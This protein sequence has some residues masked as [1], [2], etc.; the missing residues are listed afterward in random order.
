MSSMES[1]LALNT[2]TEKPEHYTY[3]KNFRVEQCTLFKEH[4]CPNHKPFTC[5]H[6][7]FWNQRRRR[8][9]RRR[10]GLFNYSPDVYCTKYDE[11][12][13]I[14]PDGE[15]CP[16][17]HKTA[18]DTEKHYHLRH[19]KTCMC[20]YDTDAKGFCKKNGLHCAYAHGAQDLRAPVLD[21]R[22]IQAQEMQ[23]EGGAANGT[24]PNN[25]D[26]ERNL[27]ED[28][29]WQDTNYVLANYKTEPCKKPPRLCR[30][31]YT[32]PQYHN[33]RD[34]RRSPQKF[35]Y[36]TTPCP[37]VKHLDEWGEPSNCESGDSCQYCHTRTEQQ[38]HPEIYKSSKCN[39]MQQTGYCPRGVFCAFAH[40]D[41]EIT[42]QR[43]LNLLSEGCT[44]LAS[45]LPNSIPQTNTNNS[46]NS[47]S[48]Q[49]DSRCSSTNGNGNSNHNSNLSNGILPSV[50]VSETSSVFG[51]R[52]GSYL[53]NS[54]GKSLLQNV[55]PQSSYPKA[56]GSG[57]EEKESI[58]RK[59]MLAIGSL[60]STPPLVQPAVS[61]MSSVFYPH[62]ETVE[63]VLGNALDDQGDSLSMDNETNKNET[64]NS[65]S[66][67]LAESGLLSGS[68]PVAIP[69]RN[70]SRNPL[71]S[72]TSPSN[73]PR[74][75]TPPTFLSSQMSQSRDHSI[76]QSGALSFVRQPNSLGST[77]FSNFSSSSYFDF[78]STSSSS[79]RPSHSPSLPNSANPSNNSG[80]NY[81]QMWD[82]LQS[83]ITKLAIWKELIT[84]ELS[85]SRSAQKRLAEFLN[86][87]NYSGGSGGH[88]S[89][90]FG[91][92]IDSLS[93]S[94]LGLRQ[95]SRSDSDAVDKVN[96]SSSLHGIW[97]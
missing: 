10:D 96:L 80:I 62:S 81:K 18:G 2:Q 21:I 8:P 69:G 44:N 61:P 35:K 30:Q 70:D 57:R 91:S 84:E 19:Y 86:V 79:V 20:M 88:S 90:A 56:P 54:I 3:L 46:T 25:L 66:V 1:K 7:H 71:N 9:V 65:I 4:Q 60:S 50:S 39:D 52:V 15:M 72:L 47:N 85:K 75:S 24:G 53:S 67:G 64:N 82:D 76:D 89:S 41:Q 95:N 40:V 14:C 23:E 48:S 93:F 94:D 12:T 74:S 38:F 16:Y 68:A 32:C 42:S 29:K 83:T 59:Q 63:S 51:N 87:A 78:T 55:E 5:F 49:T 97:K 31:G 33:N 36:R 58:I 26:K 13:G 22:E 34:R 92:D 6:W 27:G 28:P 37:H 45:F 11:A 73:S 77:K 43:E 17:L